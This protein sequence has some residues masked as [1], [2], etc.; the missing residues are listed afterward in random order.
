MQAEKFDYFV[1]SM[2]QGVSDNVLDLIRNPPDN[3]P[4][5]SLKDWLLRIFSLN[6]YTHAEAIAN[7]PLTGD[8]H[9]STLM[10]RMLCLLHA[11]HKPCFF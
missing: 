9:P 1:Q 7:L 2:T 3:D 8:M 5:Q 4:H 6:D 11:G 10:S